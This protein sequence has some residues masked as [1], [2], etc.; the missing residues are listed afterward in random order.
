MQA[1]NDFFVH[2]LPPFAPNILIRV[3]HPISTDS[4]PTSICRLPKNTAWRQRPQAIRLAQCGDTHPLLRA[5]RLL[6]DLDLVVRQAVQLVP[7]LIDLRIRRRDLPPKESILL[8]AI[9]D[10]PLSLW[11]RHSGIALRMCGT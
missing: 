9:Y 4:P 3:S 8:R 1:D 10:L 7:M 5:A 11:A 6:H 2:R